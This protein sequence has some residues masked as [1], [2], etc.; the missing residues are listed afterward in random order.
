MGYTEGVDES[1]AVMKMSDAKN[2][3]DKRWTGLQTGRTK[4]ATDKVMW[5]QAEKLMESGAL[6]EEYKT[7]EKEKKFTKCSLTVIARRAR[8]L[9]LHDGNFARALAEL[10]KKRDDLEDKIRQLS[11][12]MPK[13]GRLGR[14]MAFSR[15]KDGRQKEAE[16]D[17]E[18][19]KSQID[20]L[21]KFETKEA[22]ANQLTSEECI[23]KKRAYIRARVLAAK[24]SGTEQRGVDA[25][26]VGDW[27]ALKDGEKVTVTWGGVRKARCL[28]A[29]KT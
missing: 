12:W 20:D 8:L 21:K 28:R 23:R 18:D 24:A 15:P 2:D 3:I 22:E 7:K 26:A 29:Y 5:N 13:D 6:C 9:Y 19:V 4:I 17:L 27:N 16:D 25:V 14:K 10:E 1:I 11:S